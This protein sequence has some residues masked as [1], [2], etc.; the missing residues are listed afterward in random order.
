MGG[1][2][3]GTPAPA[4]KFTT[5]DHWPVVNTSL[6]NPT[7]S[8][9]DAT[10]AKLTFP[11]GYISGGYWVSGPLGSGTINLTISLSGADITLPIESGVIAVK[12]SDGSDG[13]IAGAVDTTALQTALTP[14]AVKFGICPGSGT[15]TSVVQTLTEGADLVTGAPQLQDTTKTCNALSIAI[16]FT[17]APTGTPSG[18]ISP[19]AAASTGCDA[20]M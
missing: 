3:S 6:N 8:I 13:T 16:G 15:F 10:N 19:S 2:D 7:G 9:T 14:V 4:P 12:L 5:A 11:N 18:V 1:T 20:G 17:M